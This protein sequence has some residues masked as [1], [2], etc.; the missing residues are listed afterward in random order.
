MPPLPTDLILIQPSSAYA[1]TFLMCSFLCVQIAGQESIIT[2]IRPC[3]AMP[4][5]HYSGTSALGEVER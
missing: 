2:I 3:K 1:Q 5:W 4:F